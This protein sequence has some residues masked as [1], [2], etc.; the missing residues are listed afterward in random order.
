M[1]FGNWRGVAL[2]F[3]ALSALAGRAKAGLFFMTS[4]ARCRPSM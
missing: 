1:R 2:A 3:V 4:R